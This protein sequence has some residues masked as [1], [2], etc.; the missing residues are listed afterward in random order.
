MSYSV[1]S[2]DPEHD[3]AAEE[4]TRVSFS[5]LRSIYVPTEAARAGAASN[6]NT[7]TRLVALDAQGA[8]VGTLLY[9]V[10]EGRVHFRSLAVHSEHRRRGVARYLVEHLSSKAAKASLRAVSLFAVAETGNVAVFERLGFRVVRQSTD[11]LS[12]LADGS[13]PATLAYMERVAS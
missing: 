5:R 10:E 4:L 3:K 11:E 7:F 9:R 8:V 12:I 13:G 1:R 6:A 2:A